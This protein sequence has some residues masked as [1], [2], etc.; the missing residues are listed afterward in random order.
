MAAKYEIKS[1]SNG[2]YMF[3]LKAG[4]GEI[5][6]TSERYKQKASAENGIQSVRQNSP[7]D[8]RYDRRTAKDNSPYF[9][10]RAANN[11]IIGRSEMYS[12]NSAMENG[13]ASVKTNG[14]G[15]RVHDQ[16]T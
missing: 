4:N 2:E 3:N 8:D 12:S 11:E 9:V 13:I 15:A 5:I 7:N 14:P 10:L 6:L 1:T 16:T